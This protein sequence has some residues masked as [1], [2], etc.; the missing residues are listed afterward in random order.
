MLY[1]P[2]RSWESVSVGGGELLN[3][4]LRGALVVIVGGLRDLVAVVAVDGDDLLAEAS[5][6]PMLMNACC[7][8]AIRSASMMG[9]FLL[10]EMVSL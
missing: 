3:E 5:V 9:E 7:S 8:A 2:P 6:L 10:T 1:R 4:L